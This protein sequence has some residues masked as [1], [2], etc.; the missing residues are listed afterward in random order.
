MKKEEE[1]TAVGFILLPIINCKLYW[2]FLQCP[3]ILEEHESLTS[4]DSAAMVLTAGFLVDLNL[5]TST[6]DTYRP[7]PAP[8]PYD[9]VLGRSQSTDSESLSDTTNSSGYE[10]MY[11]CA[12]VKGPD[13]E[14]D[15]DILLASPK[16]FE[17]RILKSGDLNVSAPEDEDVCPTCLEGALLAESH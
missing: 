9:V 10:N 17:F 11:S 7:P 3:P 15:S 14:T 1:S 16:K 4:H 5:D 13:C 6:P 12:D 8:I 2:S